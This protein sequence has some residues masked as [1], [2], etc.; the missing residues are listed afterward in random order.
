M[1]SP[2]QYNK[3]LQQLRVIDTFFPIDPRLRAMFLQEPSYTLQRVQIHYVC[4]FL[5]KLLVALSIGSL[6]ATHF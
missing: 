2:K 3:V 4:T 5:G 6:T 1:L